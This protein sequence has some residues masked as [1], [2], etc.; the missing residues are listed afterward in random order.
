MSQSLPND[1]ERFVVFRLLFLFLFLFIFVCLI[2]I[3]AFVVPRMTL[4]S[5]VVFVL[6]LLM[7]VHRW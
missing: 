3:V 5:R 2:G 7:M 6:L 4:G 1:F